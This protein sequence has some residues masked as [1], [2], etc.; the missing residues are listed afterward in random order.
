MSE[1]VP[2]IDW[3]PFFM[4]WELKGKYPRIF[5]DPQIGAVARELREKGFMKI[6]SLAPEVV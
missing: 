2:Y 4:A 1:I 3:S 5:E 6:V